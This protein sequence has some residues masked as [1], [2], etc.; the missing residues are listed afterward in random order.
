MK[1]SILFFFISIFFFPACTFHEESEINETFYFFDLPHEIIYSESFNTHDN[2]LIWDEEDYEIRTHLS[3][4][5]LHSNQLNSMSCFDV[6]NSK[7]I[8]IPLSI[9][10]DKIYEM[11]STDTLYFFKT[12]FK[13][14]TN[15]QFHSSIGFQIDYNSRFRMKSPVTLN[16]QT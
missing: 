1:Q 9:A 15:H 14:K 5:Q 8:N 6:G 13:Y 12:E 11:A 7:P 4:L 10:W 3:Y 16:S 2:S